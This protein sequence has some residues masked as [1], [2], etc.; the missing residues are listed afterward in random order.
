MNEKNITLILSPDE[1]NKILD[2][3]NELPHKHVAD[4]FQKIRLD[5][6]KQLQEKKPEDNASST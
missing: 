6:I 4:L 5:A 1:V 2:G 3:L